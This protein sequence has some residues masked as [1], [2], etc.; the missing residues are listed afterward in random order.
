MQRWDCNGK[1][2]DIR[3]LDDCAYPFLRLLG[4]IFTMAQLLLLEEVV[5]GHAGLFLA[6]GGDAG[7]T[8]D[9]GGCCQGRV[10]PPSVKN[11]DF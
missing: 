9:T 2:N 3:R 1:N 6:R 4:D 7:R 10:V 8:C 11:G 5:G